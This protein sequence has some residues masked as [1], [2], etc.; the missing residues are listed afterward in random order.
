MPSRAK[1]E[2]GCGEPE[3]AAPIPLGASD[4][5]PPARTPGRARRAAPRRDECALEPDPL[6]A[7]SPLALSTWLDGVTLGRLP[8]ADAVH[9]GQAAFALGVGRDDGGA[10]IAGASSLENRW[11]IEGAPVDSVRTGGADT[12]LPLAF[13]SGVR[14]ITGG[15]SARDRVGSGG[16]VEAEL[17][18]GGEAHEVT[19]RAWAGAQARRREREALPGAF[20]AI[21][22]RLVDPRTATATVVAT[23]PLPG[24]AGARLWYAAGVAPTFTDISFEQEGVRLVD[25]NDDGRPDLDDAGAFR[26]EPTARR[27]NDTTAYSVPM[28]ARVGGERGGHSLELTVL[29]QLARSARFLNV[30]T[31]EATTIDR[32]TALVDGIATWR[33]HTRRTQLRAQAAWHRTSRG[34]AAADERA[35]EL[36]QLQTAFIPTAEQAPTLEPGLIAACR[37]DETG[38][39]YPRI[40]NCPVP[41]GWFMRQ[42]VGLLTDVTTDRPSFSVDVAHQPAGRFADHAV[43]AGVTGEDARMVIDTRYSGGLL[44]R[45]LF[46]EHSETV[47]LVDGEGVEVCSMNIDVPCPTLDSASLA[48]RTR[49]LAAY[50]EDTWRPRPDLLI[51]LGVRWEYQQLGSRLKLSDNFAPRGGVA[52]D[53]LGRGRSR[54]AASFSRT[55]A[56]LPAGLGELVDKAPVTVRE[57]DFQESRFRVIESGFLTRVQPGVEAMTT[58]EIAFSAEIGWPRLGRLRLQSQHRWLRAGYED[59]VRGFGNPEGASRRTDL[60]GVELATSPFTDLA[61]RVGYAWGRTQGSLVGAYDPRRGAVLYTSSDFNEVTAN[62]IGTLPSDLG[63]RFYAD[64]ARQRR[65]GKHLSVEGGARLSLSSGRPRSVVAESGVWGPIYLLPRGSAERLPAV[66]ST[67][68]R[69]AARLRTTALSLEVQNLFSRETVTATDEVYAEGLFSPIDGGDASDLTFLKTITGVPA[70]R[71]LSYGS[72]TNYQLPIVVLLGVE[73]QF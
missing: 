67:D 53:P 65:F 59:T 2:P 68:V 50:L 18:R 16:L 15:F 60:I 51:D 57:I 69:L 21:R 4:A 38:D 6:A 5:R 9:D 12:R 37:D 33:R 30:A 10:V 46:A 49:H 40:T 22:G 20:T 70:R 43:R 41:T 61:L 11:T 62:T 36:P 32:S 19:A 13:L 3:E 55:F 45:S 42:G 29:G 54:V 58:D 52:W 72:A 64:L 26:V 8:V 25:R 14:V 35:G 48:Y 71:S 23:G 27:T 34:E 63:H 28:M 56:Y 7:R 31:P 39:L 17:V 44:M 66:L 1:Q 47:Q 73:S 24:L